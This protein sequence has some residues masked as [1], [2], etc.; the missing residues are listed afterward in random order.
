VQELR[1]DDLTG[2]CV[3]V[4]PGRATRPHVYSTDAISPRATSDPATTPPDSCPFCEGREAKTPPEVARVGP[5][6]PDTPGWQVRVVPNLYPVVGQEPG[7]PG[8]HEV[9]VL[10][11]AHDRQLDALSPDAAAAVFLAVRDRAAHH[12]DGGFVH[13]QALI[14]HGRAAGAS[15]E[16]P[17][18]QLV[19][20]A[21]VPPHV[22]DLLTRFA[23][24]GRDLVIDTIDAAR[25]AGCVVRDDAAVS[26]CP[27][28][29]TA[30]F[31]MRIALPSGG[32]RFDRS[33]D[34]EVRALTAGLTDAL[35]RLH[36]AL[37]AFAYN[38]VVNTAPRDDPRPFHCWIDIVP[39]LGVIAGFE[40]G[41][42][43]LVNAAAPEAT[44]AMLRDA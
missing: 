36:K 31:M 44:A 14:N 37:G 21:F 33:T 8:A 12:L 35:A 24:A 39:R 20:L 32:A 19:A 5:G 29:S 2:S 28:A 40:M 34:D 17:H 18:A 3:I 9:I 11:P 30:P 1:T 22:T 43:V 4:A 41:T 10:S 13:A 27:V 26:W 42:G 25:A 23:D 15:I 38:V 6:A 7:I 16:H